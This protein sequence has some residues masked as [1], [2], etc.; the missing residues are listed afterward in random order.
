LFA[1]PTDVLVAF[2]VLFALVLLV[3]GLGL[4]A[5]EA[6][7]QKKVTTALRTVSQD[8]ELPEARI[9]DRQ[10]EA[11]AKPGCSVTELPFVKSLDEQI[12]QAGLGWSPVAVLVATAIGIIAG[13]LLGMQIAVP[14]F[15][16]AGM[17]IFACLFGAIPVLY[18]RMKRFKRLGAFEAQFPETLDFLARSLRAGHAFSVAL[19]MIAEESPEP[20]GVEFRI[21][22]HEQNLGSPLEV[23][24]MNLTKRIPLLDVRFF[25]AAILLQRDTGG[26]LAEILD[27]LAYVIRER[28]RLKGHVKA[29]SAHG[30]I[31]ATV[32]TIMPLLTMLGLMLVAPSYLG[33]LVANPTG[34]YLIVAAVVLMFVGYYWMRRVIDI[35]V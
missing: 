26:N 28:F 7:R 19:E 35:K 3:I 16:E 25:V 27:K 9:L 1:I 32:L 29:V 24:M 4:R 21:L 23:A 13:V 22:F 33:Y 10:Q 20:T 31:T 34:K 8:N 14:V 12:R 11:G 17:A 15:R 30:R 6:E 2:F 18:V 5:I